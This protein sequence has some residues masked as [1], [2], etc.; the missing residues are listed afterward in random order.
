MS[1][2]RSAPLPRAIL[3]GE[4]EGAFARLP[5]TV[6]ANLRR[7]NSENA[8]LWNAFC[9]RPGRALTLRRVLAVPPL[10]GTAEPD[11]PHD[12]LEPYFWGYHASGRRLEGLDEALAAVDGQG[13]R[14]EVDMILRGTQHL[15]L[16]EAKNLSALGRCGRYQ[17]RTC[18]EVH[19]SAEHWLD[20]CRYWE[21]SAAL[22]LTHLDLG[23]RP[24]PGTL[25]PPCAGHYQLARTLLVGQALAAHLDLTLYVWV[26]L[27]RERW[28]SLERTWLDFVGRVRDPDLWRRMRV[29]GW[30]DMAAWTS[31]T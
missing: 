21:V 22:F 1:A 3:S 16:V 20:S 8:R 13:P 31:R 10:W 30:E 7:P 23:P 26:L 18:P 19:R 25:R 24:G 15:V 9:P 28:R 17:R 27:P 6:I 2:R 11:A 12:V 29:V 4:E 5:E 14:T